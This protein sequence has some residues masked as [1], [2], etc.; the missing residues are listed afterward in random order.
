VGRSAKAMPAAD[1]RV[2]AVL[3]LVRERGGRVTVPRRALVGASFTVDR[4]ASAEELVDLVRA[5]EPDAHLSTIYRTLEDL[6]SLGVV[7]HSHLGHGA[8]TYQ[9]EATPTPTSSVRSAGSRSTRHRT[10]SMTLPVGFA[11]RSGSRSNPATSRSRGRAST[12]RAVER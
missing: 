3:E 1:P 5:T 11:A 9:L 6:E 12:A 4:R 8:A 7:S 2:A 10:R